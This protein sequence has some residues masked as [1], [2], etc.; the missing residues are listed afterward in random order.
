MKITSKEARERFSE[1]LD[2]V[3][4][5]EEVVILRRGKPVVRLVRERAGRVSRLPDLRE[6]RAS[7]RARGIPLSELLLKE[8]AE[9][10]Y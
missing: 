4:R 3:A 8:R 9:A 6:F 2:R 7:I 1:L 10:R 5:G